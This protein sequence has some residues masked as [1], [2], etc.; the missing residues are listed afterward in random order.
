MVEVDGG[1]AALPVDVDGVVLPTQDFSA[2]DADAYPRIGEIRT[3]PS[4]SPW[5]IAGAIRP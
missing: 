5:A 4:G 1:T 2:A 3:T